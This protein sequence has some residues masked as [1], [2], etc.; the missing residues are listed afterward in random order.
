MGRRQKSY[1]AASAGGASKVKGATSFISVGKRR[2]SAMVRWST[3]YGVRYE[4]CL[5]DVRSRYCIRIAGGSKAYTYKYT[6]TYSFFHMAAEPNGNV[7]SQVSLSNLKV[8]P[9]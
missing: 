4:G 9:E 3:M 5:S 7:K 1:V 2:F 6:Y 8:C